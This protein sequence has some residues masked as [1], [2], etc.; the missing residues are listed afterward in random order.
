MI[1]N[2]GK[3]KLKGNESFNIREGWLRKGMRCVKEYNDLFSR[4]DSMELL[5]V[6]SKMVKSIRFW[7]Q[8]T[9]LTVE[10]ISGKVRTQNITKNFGEIIERNDPYFEDIFTLWLIHWQIVK[11]ENLCMIWHLFFNE[12]EGVNF[13]KDDMLEAIRLIFNKIIPE[14]ATY[15]ESSLSDDCNSV[16]RMYY[17]SKNDD[18]PE[19]NLSSPL[20]E[21]GLIQR[22]NKIKNSFN[23]DIPN[24]DKL[25]KLVILYVIVSNM[26][27]D[28]KSIS[29]D[30]LIKGKNNIGRVFNLSRNIINEYLDQLRIAGYLTINRTAGLDIIYIETLMSPEQIME[31]YYEK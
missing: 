9:G 1:D 27:N 23:K 21:L 29:I 24:M 8:A 26:E 30:E 11:N 13:T 6:G 20:S 18:D 22:E 28:K 10:N 2:I 4:E 31:L 17:S 14:K 7:L 25:D 12:F 19:E 3:V 5:G 15:S 16:L